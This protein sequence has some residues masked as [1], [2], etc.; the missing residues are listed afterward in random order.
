MIFTLIYSAMRTVSAYSMYCKEGYLVDDA[1][2]NSV[3]YLHLVQ[4]KRK[5]VRKE[6]LAEE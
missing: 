2:R 4:V 1:S 5:R 3:K 6:K